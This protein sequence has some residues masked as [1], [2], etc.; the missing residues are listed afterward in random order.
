MIHAE[1]WRM[2][3]VQSRTGLSKSTIYE[4]IAQ[5]SFPEPVPLG[6]RAVGFLSTEVQDW[7]EERILERDGQR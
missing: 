1:I 5:G 6:A 2:P 3:T 7:I 4:R